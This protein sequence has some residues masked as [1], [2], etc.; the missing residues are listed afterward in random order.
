MIF[1][2][3]SHADLVLWASYVSKNHQI[4]E[5]KQEKLLFEGYLE[6]LSNKDATDQEIFDSMSHDL[7]TLI[8]SVKVYSCIL[9]ERRFEKLDEIHFEKLNYVKTNTNLLLDIIFKR[10]EKPKLRKKITL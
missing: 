5:W 6:V 8:A 3:I 9:L 7:R 4:K 10:L 2:S 1:L